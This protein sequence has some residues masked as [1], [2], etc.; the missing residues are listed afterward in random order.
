MASGSTATKTGVP[1]ALPAELDAAT[2]P[3]VDAVAEASRASTPFFPRGARLDLLAIE[4]AAYAD[5]AAGTPAEPSFPA[6]LLAAPGDAAASGSAGGSAGASAGARPGTNAAPIPAIVSTALAE[7]VEALTPGKTFQMIVGGGPVTFRVVEVR[8]D[9]PTLASGSRFAIVDLDQLRAAVSPDAA[10]PTVAF[11]RAPDGAAEA[12]RAAAAAVSPD[13]VV[14]GRAESAAETRGTPLMEAVVA[15]LALAVLVA[16]LYAA[17]AV[18]C[19]LALSASARA[20]EVAHLR[21]L[22]LSRAQSA[23]LV[24]AEHGPTVA[25]AF[26]VGVALGIG[27]FVVVGPA[28]GTDAIVGSAVTVPLAVEPLHLLGIMVAVIAI[29]A[30]GMAVAAA[31]QRRAVPALAV[32]RRMA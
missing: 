11:V 28:L 26:V 9:F 20:V 3:G 10:R 14:A 23:W 15:G 13:L 22:G 7:G 32:R 21:K 18:S 31:I 6:D 30:V 2:L 12:I 24:V 19:A 17:L 4:A 16:A 1:I 8:D 27:L 25:V 29:V 5:L